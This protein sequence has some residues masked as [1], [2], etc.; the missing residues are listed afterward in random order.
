MQWLGLDTSLMIQNRSYVHI[1]TSERQFTLKN[2]KKKHKFQDKIMKVYEHQRIPQ[3]IIQLGK[4]FLVLNKTM[5][6]DENFVSLM[7]PYGKL[8]A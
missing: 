3:Q 7:K 8:D 1:A 6:K 4:D 2:T 5:S